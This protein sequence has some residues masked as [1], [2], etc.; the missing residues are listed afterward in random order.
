MNLWQILP[1]NLMTRILQIFKPKHSSTI[2]KN[3]AL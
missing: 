3:G 1:T 2:L